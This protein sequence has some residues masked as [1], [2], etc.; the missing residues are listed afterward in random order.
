MGPDGRSH[1]DDP[2][3]ATAHRNGGGRIFGSLNSVFGLY[4]ALARL[5]DRAGVEKYRIVH[6]FRD[7]FAVRFL[8]A[9]GAIDDLQTL[10]GH[11]DLSTT[12]RYVRHGKEQRAID[13]G[14]KYFP[15][16]S[17]NGHTNGNG[18]HAATESAGELALLE[19]SS[20]GSHAVSWSCSE[21]RRRIT[22]TMGHDIDQLAEA[23]RQW[24]A[25]ADAPE[26]W[27]SSYIAKWTGVHP[28]STPTDEPGGRICPT[29]A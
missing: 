3:A 8:E 25:R 17:R 20:S 6:R 10:L 22:P 18:A 16:S 11:A 5:C 2:P 28:D 26:M 23:I 29:T 19:G 13:A 27:L 9:G 14:R 15:W 7:S 1:R 4:H 12:L 21:R 24:T